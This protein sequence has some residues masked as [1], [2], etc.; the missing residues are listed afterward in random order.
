M[1]IQFPHRGFFNYFYWF[2]N[3]WLVQL[4]GYKGGINAIQ[5]GG[6]VYLAAEVID[7]LQDLGLPP[8]Q[9]RE[10]L[11][12]PVQMENKLPFKH[13]K[14][15]ENDWKSKRSVE[16][17]EGAGW[18]GALAQ[19]RHGKARLSHMHTQKRKKSPCF[20]LNLC[21]ET[22]LSFIFKSLHMSTSSSDIW[23]TLSSF[24]DTTL[25]NNTLM[26]SD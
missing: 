6:G 20:R 26:P 24:T 3:I 13:M 18:A 10:R 16:G 23:V 14:R 17:T 15:E 12:F 8:P 4:I 21:Y 11:I 25:Y 22:D 9:R 2:W 5:P 19:Y 1:W 7:L